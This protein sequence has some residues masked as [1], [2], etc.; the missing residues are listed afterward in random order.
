[1]R[2]SLND[3]WDL[4][5]QLATNVHCFGGL[6]VV[7]V[8]LERLICLTCKFVGLLEKTQNMKTLNKYDSTKSMRVR[9]FLPCGPMCIRAFIQLWFMTSLCGNHGLCVGGNFTCCDPI[10]LGGDR[11]VEVVVLKGW[12][13]KSGLLNNVTVHFT[14][15][16]KFWKCQLFC[17]QGKQCLFNA[18]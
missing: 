4:I 6:W 13:E 5:K 12:K 11:C 18:S 14:L 15:F 17:V 8:S 16:V 1:M 9:E 10:N 7:F 3:D 2:C